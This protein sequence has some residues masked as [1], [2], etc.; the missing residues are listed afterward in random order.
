MKHTSF[1]KEKY[2]SKTIMSLSLLVVHIA[3]IEGHDGRGEVFIQNSYDQKH[4]NKSHFHY[5]NI[6]CTPLAWYLKPLRLIK[7]K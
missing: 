7:F 2:N 3:E 5:Y 1:V 4:I 6:F